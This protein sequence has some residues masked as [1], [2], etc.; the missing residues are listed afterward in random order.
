MT[1]EGKIS[2]EVCHT[3]YGHDKQLQH[4]WLPKAK[5]QQIAALL[6]QGVTREKILEDIRESAMNEADEFKRYHLTGKKDLSNIMNSFGLSQVQKHTN[7]Q[8][9]VRAWV[10][11]LGC[12]REQPC[13]FL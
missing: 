7:D 5:R 9:S 3:H 6:Q 10:E 2:A 1:E 8:K 12:W 13:S 11:E 4:T